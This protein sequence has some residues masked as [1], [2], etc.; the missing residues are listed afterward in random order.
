M[1]MIE[2]VC[3]LTRLTNDHRLAC[4]ARVPRYSRVLISTGDDTSS[5]ASEHAQVN[6]IELRRSLPL[7]DDNRT[8]SSCCVQ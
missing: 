5:V 4:A 2:S 8:S 3:Q 1:R 6:G 7:V